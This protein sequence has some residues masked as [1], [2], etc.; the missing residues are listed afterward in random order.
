MTAGAQDIAGGDVGD[1]RSSCVRPAAACVPLP[2]A[3]G[4]QKNDVHLCAPFFV[5]AVEKSK[6]GE[7]TKAELRPG[8]ARAA[9]G[10]IPF[11]IP[12]SISPGSLCNCA[13]PARLSSCLDWFPAPRS[14]G[15]QDGA[16]RRS[17]NGHLPPTL[18]RTASEQPRPGRGRNS[19]AKRVRRVR[20]PVQGNSSRLDGP[21]GCRGC[22]R[23]SAEGSW[24]ISM[25]I[26]GDRRIEVGESNDQQAA[27]KHVYH[28]AD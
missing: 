22:G 12:G 16:W 21:D 27:D 8:E 17:R 23:R 3:G 14:T 26:E 28:G 25:G 7:V 5:Q 2:G 19:A 15:D 10:G 9:R 11:F 6:G 24:L 4:A 20:S 13:S 18:R 1:R